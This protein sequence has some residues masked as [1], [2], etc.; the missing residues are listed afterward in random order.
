MKAIRDHQGL[1]LDQAAERTGISKAML[2]QIE[3]GQSV[4]TITTLWKI[5]TGYR[6]PLTYFLEEPKS[7]YTLADF[8]SMEPVYAEERAMR[9]YALFPYQP[10]QNFEMLYIEFDA[11]C[12]HTSGSHLPNVEEY[13][14]VQI[15]SLTIC[16]GNEEIPLSTGQCFR[17]R[18]DVPHRYRN[19]SDTVC[20]I[21]NIIFYTPAVM[22]E[23]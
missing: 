12:E 16:V 1:S 17:F 8:H 2:S 15:G 21:L 23:R 20:V 18:A 4:P 6:V 10:V 14:F 9:T 19:V 3:R 11:G 13:I 5:S 22:T 7:S